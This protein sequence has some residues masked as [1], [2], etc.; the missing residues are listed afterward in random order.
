MSKKHIDVTQL[1]DG[2]QILLGTVNEVFEIVV[3]DAEKALVTIESAT[4][5]GQKAEIAGATKEGK[6]LRKKQI[7]PNAMLQ[8]KYDVLGSEEV[9]NT[10]HV[11]TA[12]ITSPDDSWSYE[13]EWEGV[14]PHALKPKSKTTKKKRKK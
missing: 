7:W 12:K 10:S 11:I 6:L 14:N 1:D 9:F 2:T 3:I 8:I 5:R 13:I 4:F